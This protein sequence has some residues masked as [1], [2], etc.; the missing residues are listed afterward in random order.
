VSRMQAGERKEKICFKILTNFVSLEET[1]RL[2]RAGQNIKVDMYTLEAF[3]A[4]FDKEW[5]S[6]TPDEQAE[7]FNASYNIRIPSG[8]MP[9]RS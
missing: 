1:N 6:P 4:E 7:G 8:F 9:R 5:A 3:G 2:T